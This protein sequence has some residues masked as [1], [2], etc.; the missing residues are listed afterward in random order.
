MK[1]RDTYWT[2][3]ETICSEIRPKKE[4]KRVSC[5]SP[6]LS[7]GPGDLVDDV[8]EDDVLVVGVGAHLLPLRVLPQA[9]VVT[10]EGVAD[11]GVSGLE[12]LGLEG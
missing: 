6:N 12:R 1:C 3:F 8:G 11:A 2:K 5:V 9:D 4:Q 7:V 10:K